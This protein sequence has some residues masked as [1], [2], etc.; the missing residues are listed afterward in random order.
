MLNHWRNVAELWWGQQGLEQ[1]WGNGWLASG[2][3]TGPP[4]RSWLHLG[5]VGKG[6]EQAAKIL[7]PTK[8]KWSPF[9]V[10]HI[11]IRRGC[12]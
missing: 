1:D 10:L 4:R 2:S 5:G 8:R 9:I 3:G 7:M 11:W 12:V 6:R